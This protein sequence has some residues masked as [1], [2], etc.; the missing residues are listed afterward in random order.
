MLD[1][2]FSLD[3]LYWILLA[4]YI[5]ACIGLIVIVLLQ[6]GKGTGFAGA[7]GVGVGAETVFGPR[8][9]RSLPVKLTYVAAA[10]FMIIALVMSMI[11]GRIGKGQA[12]ELADVDT[13]IAASES[14][15]LA[16]LGL[17]SGEG[18]AVDTAAEDTSDESV[19]GEIESFDTDSSESAEAS[20]EADAETAADE[21]AP[22]ET[23]TVESE[24]APATDESEEAKPNP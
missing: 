11:S 9:R 19:Q 10:T 6:K 15:G 24:D 21:S 23:D 12:P 18:G 14:S 22:G 20:D 5:P 1:A 2:I 13:E 17:G 4:F 3:T 8:A 16:D 7:F